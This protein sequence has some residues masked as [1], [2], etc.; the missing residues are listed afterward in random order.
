MTKYKKTICYVISWRIILAALSLAY[1]TAVIINYCKE[2]RVKPELITV[3]LL[4]VF[5]IILVTASV[6][7]L[8]CYCIKLKKIKN[9]CEY[10]SFEEA[11]EEN[12]IFIEGCHFF[13]SDFFLTLEI[14]AKIYYK[15]ISEIKFRSSNSTFLICIR[16][17]NNK[18]YYIKRFYSKYPFW[19][20]GHYIKC[21]KNFES[22]LSY[23][24]TNNPDI[25]FSRYSL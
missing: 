9:S 11:V 21:Q 2:S 15:D 25:K 22:M 19:V 6:I 4:S 18:K 13:M 10:S 16:T 24:S 8:I 1:G 17:K 20:W 23:F 5:C 12:G 14:P 3:I 7:S